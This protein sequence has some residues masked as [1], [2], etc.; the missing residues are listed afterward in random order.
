MARR[1][2]FCLTLL[3][4]PLLLLVVPGVAG[5]GTVSPVVA[6]V[7]AD[8]WPEDCISTFLATMMR[9]LY[10]CPGAAEYLLSLSTA[11]ASVCPSRVRMEQLQQMWDTCLR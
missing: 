9:R 5:G 4:P 3:L 11:I 10:S 8:P 7:F 2:T 1:L 6:A